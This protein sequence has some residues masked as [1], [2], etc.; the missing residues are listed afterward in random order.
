[1][2]GW[3]SSWGCHQLAVALGAPPFLVFGLSVK[4]DRL[5]WGMTPFS[6][7]RL[8]VA[9]PRPELISRLPSSTLCL[10]CLP[11]SSSVPNVSSGW[12]L[13]LRI[14]TDFPASSWGPL[15]KGV[16][17]WLYLCSVTKALSLLQAFQASVSHLGQSLRPGLS[18]WA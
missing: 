12:N 14:W 18:W 17:N 5:G 16:S 9:D 6:G 7:T 8:L 15:P 3:V 13:F 10:G 2:G 11:S 4:V 1:L